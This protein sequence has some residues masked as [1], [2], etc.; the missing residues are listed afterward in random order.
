MQDVERRL[1]PSFA[2][3]ST[4]IAESPSSLTSATLHQ[5]LH[6]PNIVALYSVLSISAAQYHA[7]ELCPGGNL[8]DFVSS[9]DPPIL[10]EADIR[11]LL[12]GMAN[13]LLYLRREKIVHRNINPTNILLTGSTEPVSQMLV[14]SPGF[15]WRLNWSEIIRL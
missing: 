7:L 4:P 10:S 6:H 5:A 8:H 3:I 13:A 14:H 1:K 2:Q 9:R 11:R 12:K 15:K